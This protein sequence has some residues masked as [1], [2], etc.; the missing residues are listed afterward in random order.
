M[1]GPFT[2][3]GQ[4]PLTQQ[5]ITQQ[6][7]GQT[8]PKTPNLGFVPIFTEPNAGQKGNNQGQVQGE[9]NQRTGFNGVMYGQGV[10]A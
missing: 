6:K 8:P 9:P 7:Q 5:E 10:V 2:G 1:G 3:P 4:N